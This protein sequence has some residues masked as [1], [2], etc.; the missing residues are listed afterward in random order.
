MDLFFELLVLPE[1]VSVVA[2]APFPPVAE[3]MARLLSEVIG[4]FPMWV[5][6]M[7]DTGVSGV[8]KGSRVKSFSESMLE[9]LSRE[10]CCGVFHSLVL[11]VLLLPT[12]ACVRLSVNQR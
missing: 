12:A 6:P 7:K 3:I 4:M 11:F 9:L 10:R 5:H 8:D 2:V 1:D